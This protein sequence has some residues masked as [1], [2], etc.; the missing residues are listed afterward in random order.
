VNYSRDE[1]NREFTT[2][3]HPYGLI[4]YENSFYL[5]GYSQEA[6]DIRTYKLQRLKE[7][8][9]TQKP[10]T[11]PDDFSLEQCIKGGFGIIYDPAK[12]RTTIRCEFRDW[13]ARVVREQKWHRTQV[14][15]KDDGETVLASFLLDSTEEFKRWVL[16]FGAYMTVVEPKSFIADIKKTAGRIVKNHL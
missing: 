14:I 11:S 12:K 2:E 15:E 1:G 4:V 5:I 13:A 16:G 3:F 7:I 6:Q 9:L 8:K 10:F